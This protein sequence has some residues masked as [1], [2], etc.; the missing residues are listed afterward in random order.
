MDEVLPLPAAD[1]EIVANGSGI[2]QKKKG[3]ASQQGLR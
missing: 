3:L 2:F 1:N